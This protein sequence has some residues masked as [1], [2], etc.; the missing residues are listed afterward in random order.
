MNWN[1]NLHEIFSYLRINQTLNY[2]NLYF[3]AI[4]YILVE[5]EWMFTNLLK[6]A[7]FSLQIPDLKKNSLK[8]PLNPFKR[9]IKIQQWFTTGK[10]FGGKTIHK[11][12]KIHKTPWTKPIRE[13]FIL[14]FY[15]LALTYW[16]WFDLV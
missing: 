2:H 4:V 5:F 13:I 12:F 16:K 9:H 7:A 8:P 6:S 15:T 1:I 14:T 11:A 3:K 10:I